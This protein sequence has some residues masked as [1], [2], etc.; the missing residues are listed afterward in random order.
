MQKN[1]INMKKG[2]TLALILL[3]VT[4]ITQNEVKESEGNFPY[5]FGNAIETRG[6]ANANG[7]EGVAGSQTTNWANDDVSHSAAYA[8]GTNE[9]SANTNGQ[10][11]FTNQIHGANTNAAA[12]NNGDGNVMV[13]SW[14]KSFTPYA[15]Y[16]KKYYAHYMRYLKR[17]NRGANH[18][19]MHMTNHA[20]YE[21]KAPMVGHSFDAKDAEVVTNDHHGY[22]H[23]YGHG[24][25]HGVMEQRNI[26]NY[27]AGWAKGQVAVDHQSTRASGNNTAA[28]SGSG[29]YT[30]GGLTFN[31]GQT[32]GSAKDGW[33]LSKNSDYGQGNLNFVNSNGQSGAWG[34]NAQSSAN[35]NYHLHN[36]A[37]SNN[38]Q[39]WGQA[40]GDGAIAFSDMDANQH[41][42][43]A[44]VGGTDTYAT[45]NKAVS[46]SVVQGA[47][48]HYEE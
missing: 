47:P 40:E 18:R 9:S 44:M 30:Y 6:I 11:L 5:I 39:A 1:L 20:A 15:Q 10:S 24:H 14:S 38:G 13:D 3:S 29:T 28:S 8:N 21:E 36:G 35:S 19:D 37:V 46:K 42:Y 23:G 17:L 34:Q 32:T 43:G 26:D 2:F 25:D 4:S 16:Y 27:G 48:Y 7:D 45:G 41:G 33:A 31:V 22:G 12:V